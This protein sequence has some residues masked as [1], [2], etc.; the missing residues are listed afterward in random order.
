MQGRGYATK[1]LIRWRD[2][3]ESENSWV[4][5]RDMRGHQAMLVAFR[6]QQMRRNIANYCA[7]RRQETDDEE[8]SGE[9]SDSSSES[10]ST[11]SAS[12]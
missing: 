3:P 12:V 5:L 4:S 1:Y 2:L 8:E 6:K 10:S 11:S 7:K 9:I